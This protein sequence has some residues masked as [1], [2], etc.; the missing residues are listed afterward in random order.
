MFWLIYDEDDYLILVIRLVVLRIFGKLGI[1]VYLQL[2]WFLLCFFWWYGA[3]ICFVSIFIGF[4]G[5][6]LGPTFIIDYILTCSLN[7]LRVKFV[8]YITLSAF[9]FFFL[10]RR[11]LNFDRVT[12][13]L[14]ESRLGRDGKSRCK[15]A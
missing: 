14:T 10:T 5:R 4:L 9:L 7:L 1:S 2:W 12:F 15:E 6:V 3:R 13:F 8:H 11:I